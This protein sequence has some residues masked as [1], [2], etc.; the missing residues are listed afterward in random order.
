[1]RDGVAPDY[2]NGLYT[3]VDPDLLLR[4]LERIQHD[5]LADRERR[6][7]GPTDPMTAPP[8]GDSDDPV[9]IVTQVA[10]AAL[11]LAKYMKA[12]P[13]VLKR[14]D[15]IA[16]STR[17]ARRGMTAKN[18]ARLGQFSD[19]RAL[20]LL[21]D[22]PARV[23][24][25]HVGVEKPTFKQAREVQN[26]AIVAVL[27]ELPIRVGNVAD[28]DLARHFQGRVGPGTGKWLVS[29]AAHEVKNAETIDGEFTEATSALLDRYSRCSGRR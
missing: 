4:G 12:E 9:P 15:E 16:A 1:M 26:A 17:V 23:F 6:R 22:L 25:R 21:L 18:K 20:K 29:I 13:A 19:D 2:F 24:A 14:F 10:Y 11:S 5:V 7:A 28:L 27:I 3:L 8:T